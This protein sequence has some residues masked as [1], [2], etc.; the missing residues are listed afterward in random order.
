MQIYSVDQNADLGQP[1]KWN[2]LLKLLK[3]LPEKASM[4]PGKKGENNAEMSNAAININAAMRCF[5]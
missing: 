5:C 3:P 4:L 2:L 1:V